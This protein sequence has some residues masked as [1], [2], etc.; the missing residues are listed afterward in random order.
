MTYG[1]SADDFRNYI[2]SRGRDIPDTWTDTMIESAF[3]LSSEWL[4]LRY[5][6][7]WIG[8]KKTYEQ[9]RSWPRQ[10]A[11]TQTFPSHLFSEDEI[12]EQVVK[13]CYELTYRELTSPGCLTT[14]FKPNTYK[15]V[16]ISGAVSVEYS[17]QAYASDVQLQIPVVD[18]MMSVLIDKNKNGETSQISGK[19]Y[20]V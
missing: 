15:S 14:D 18:Y 20:R 6:D 19:A 5:E 3:L 9:E 7:V 17:V 4:D 10:A 8:Y 13:A 11:V 12:P 2:I 16:S 1:K